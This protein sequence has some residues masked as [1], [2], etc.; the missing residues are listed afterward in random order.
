MKALHDV[1]CLD[2]IGR[3]VLTVLQD[4]ARISFRQLGVKVGLSTPA[5]ADR[6]RRLEATGI[7]TGY[8]AEVSPARIGLPI[9][10]YIRLNISGTDVAKVAEVIG[11]L[12]EVLEC[13]RLT[14]GDS[15]I[16]KVV[17]GSIRHLERVIDSLRPH[18]TTTTSIVMSTP[19]PSRA[20][21]PALAD[22]GCP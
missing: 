21:D 11:D 14:G 4:D 20:V 1:R 22:T 13:H 19:V 18:G 8:R 6:V 7:L 16:I 3:A 17:V 12:P 2:D 15:F 5:V 9:S 10:A